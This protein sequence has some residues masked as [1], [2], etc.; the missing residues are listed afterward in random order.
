MW[1]VEYSSEALKTLIRMDRAIAKR[2][3][4]KIVALARNPLAANNNV[5]KLVGI[6]GYRLR[7]GDWRIIYTLRHEVLTVVVVRVGHR[8]EIYQ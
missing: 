5:K 4:S 6:D 7:V 2:L 3:R 8:K 1:S